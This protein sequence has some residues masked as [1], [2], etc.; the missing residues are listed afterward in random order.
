MTSTVS[1]GIAWPL[2]VFMAVILVARYRWFNDNPYNRYLNNAL[3]F[4]FLMQLLREQLVQNTLS[5]TTFISIADIQQLCSVLVIIVSAECMG[6]VLVW[7]GL[8]LAET[9]KRH[10]YYRLAALILSAVFFIFGNHARTAGQTI[11]V[12]GG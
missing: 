4:V 7:S 6:L 1:G 8:S 3:V 9:R 12:A 5:R 11:N 10:R 2:I